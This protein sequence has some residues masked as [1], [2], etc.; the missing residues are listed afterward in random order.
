VTKDWESRTK[1]SPRYAIRLAQLAR[2]QGRIKPSPKCQF[3]GKVGPVEGHHEDYAKPLDLIWLCRTCHRTFDLFDG[4]IHVFFQHLAEV[5]HLSI[6]SAVL[7]VGNP[8]IRTI[9]CTLPETPKNIVIRRLAASSTFAH[10]LL[11]LFL[12]SLTRETA[13]ERLRMVREGA[14]QI[15]ARNQ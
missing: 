11:F 13:P 14:V 7:S 4:F 12:S 1:G 8:E 2:E 3:C 5:L 10:D 9:L 15:E 6:P